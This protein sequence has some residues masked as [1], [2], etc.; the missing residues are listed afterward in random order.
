MD[1]AI[2]LVDNGVI[3]SGGTDFFLAGT[4]RRIGDDTKIG[5]HSWS[6]DSN[7]AT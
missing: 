4:T 6:D 1:I 3:A 5:V 2:H 7:E